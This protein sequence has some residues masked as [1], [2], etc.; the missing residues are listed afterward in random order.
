[1]PRRS[2][3]VHQH[4]DKARRAAL[5]AVD[6][7]NRVGSGFR[8][9]TYVMLMNVAWLSLFHAIFYQR[10]QKPWHG[11]G[12]GRSRRYDRTDGEPRHWDL[13]ECMRQYWKGDNPPERQNLE[14]FIRLRNK[15]EHRECPELDPVLYGECQAM[16]MNFEDLLVEQFG[17]DCALAGEFGI[18]LQFSALRPTEQERA[19]R[20]LASEAATEVRAFIESFRADLPNDVLESTK[21]ALNVFLIPKIANR[22]SAA[23]LSVEF[24][25]YDA[26]KPEEMESLTQV[27]ALIKERQ[28]SVA[29]KGLLRPGEIVEELS[30]RLPFKVTMTTHTR[31]WKHYGVRPLSGDPNPARTTPKFCVYDELAR[32]YGYTTQ[33]LEF[34]SE[35]LADENKFRAVTGNAPVIIQPPTTPVAG[36]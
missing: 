32:S 34:L 14:F 9:R 19:L 16:L 3:A 18:A 22:K 31:A 28:V 25:P 26:S 23:D 2:Q 35:E 17:A 20:R 6:N 24:V 5:T 8:T 36:E 15:I 1:M 30:K 12:T 7:Y 4:L 27:T 21:F 33:W 11:Q 10:K 29:S 13:A